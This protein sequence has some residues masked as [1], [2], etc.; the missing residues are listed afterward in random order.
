MAPYI[1]KHLS[2]RPFK[3]VIEL[4]T[5]EL[6]SEQFGVIT[7]IDVKETMR[8]KLAVGFRNYLILGA[9]NPP[10]AHKALTLNDKI[11]V[12]LPCNVVVQE[13]DNTIEVSAMDPRVMMAGEENPEMLMLADEIGQKLDRVLNRLS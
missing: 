6:K 1:T 5:E 13:W 7:T 3:E 10:F 4:V 9:C 2:K 12:L 8:I 11:G